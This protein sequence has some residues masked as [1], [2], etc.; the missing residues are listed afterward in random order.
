MT[1]T[2]RLTEADVALI[3]RRR[4]AGDGFGRVAEYLGAHDDQVRKAYDAHLAHLE[5]PPKVVQRH[6]LIKGPLALTILEI[7][8]EDP[9]VTFTD[10]GKKLEQHDPPFE[11]IPH[12]TS[13][14]R[15]L[16]R[17][18]WHPEEEP[19]GV[20]SAFDN[21]KKPEEYWDK[22]VWSGE[23][24]VVASPEYK[25]LN[26][27]VHC[28]H[29]FWEIPNDQQLQPGEFKVTFGL[30]SQRRFDIQKY[31]YLLQNCVI[32]ELKRLNHKYGG[33]FVLMQDNAGQHIANSNLA[34]IEKEKINFLE[35]S[36]HSPYLSPFENLW[37]V[38]KKRLC[39][40]H[41]QFASR[42]V[43]IDAVH[44]EWKNIQPTVCEHVA[45]SLPKHLKERMK[46]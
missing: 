28:S 21:R 12:R 32:S 3:V 30:R 33:K 4:T 1:N 13:I 43:L 8:R 7:V 23:V 36:Q 46:R 2:H 27:Y 40:G 19:K 17:E 35:W 5:L 26:V 37:S 9:T 16:A 6:R 41:I 14:Q 39:N 31:F 29:H 38:L 22:I 25:K 18:V 20:P 34:F 11:T 44:H 45:D 10:I 15:F 42:Q 24:T